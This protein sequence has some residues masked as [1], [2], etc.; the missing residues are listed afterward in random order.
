MDGGST[1]QSVD[2]IRKWESRLLGWSSSKDGGQ[3]AAI[4]EG[5][6]RGVAPYVCW[7][8]SDDLFMPNG[9]KKMLIELESLPSAPGVYARAWNELYP[10]GRFNSVWV[11][12]FS[13][14]RL[15]KRCIVSQPATLIRRT[16]WDDV[17]G[18]NEDLEMAMDYDLW[19]RIFK[20]AGALSFLDQYVAINTI[21]LKTKTSTRRR[22]HYQEAMSV[23]KKH[24]GSIPLKWWLYMPYSVGLKSLQIKFQNIF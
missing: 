13:A 8:N 10:S 15:S 2:I 18:L 9:L 17:G 22:L 11:E 21:H 5:I 7:L 20:N 16:I 12:P 3:A 24:Y 1:D 14:E 6:S 23:V 4:N 19:W